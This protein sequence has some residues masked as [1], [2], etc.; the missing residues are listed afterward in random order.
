MPQSENLPIQK[1]SNPML[2]LS[3]IGEQPIP[4]LLPIRHLK[5]ERNLLIYTSKTKERARLLRRLIGG[6]EDLL[7]DAY[8]FPKILA[9]L[10][11]RLA[12][13]ATVQFNLT[14][15]TKMMALAAYALAAQKNA[16]F[17]YVESEKHHSLLYRYQFQNGLPQLRETSVMPTLIT[18]GEYLKAHLPGFE[19]RGFSTDERGNLTEGGLFEKAVYEALK[20][21]G[22]DVL[23]GVRPAGVNDQIEIDLVFRVDNQV[24]IAEVKLGGGDSGKRGL[25]QL[26]MAGEQAYLGTYTAQFMIVAAPRLYGRAQGLAARRGVTVITLPEYQHGKPLPPVAAQRLTSQICQRL[27]GHSYLQ[28]GN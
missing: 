24:G 15:G 12:N 4:N 8:D 10:Q 1:S 2:L 3:L 16:E 20:Q 17:M 23:A 5:P 25:D 27:V 11:E 21:R 14:G 13:E 6:S 19:E 18:A 28:A 26:K 22:F 9:Q 7:V